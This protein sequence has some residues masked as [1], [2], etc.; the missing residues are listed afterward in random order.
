MAAMISGA[1]TTFCHAHPV[2]GVKAARAVEKDRWCAAR[3]RLG[4]DARE[5]S[6][7]A[8]YTKQIWQA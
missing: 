1:A 5:A 6:A 3:R 8:R 2:A 4:L 7:R